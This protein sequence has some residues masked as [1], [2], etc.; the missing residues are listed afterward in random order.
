MQVSLSDVAAKAGVSAATVSR[1]LNGKEQNRIPEATRSRV[2]QVALDLNYHPNR[3]AR[4]LQSRRTMNIGVLL[5]GMLNPFFAELLDTLEEM[6]VNVGYD[7]MPATGRNVHGPDGSAP[8]GWP[9]DGII[10]WALA[11]QKINPAVWQISSSVP[12]VYVGY[13]RTDDTDFVAHDSAQG[14]RLALEHL[15]ERGHRKIAFASPP[16]LEVP[17]RELRKATFEAFC[18][19]RQIEPMR[20][21][22]AHSPDM[23]DWRQSG[24]RSVGFAAGQRLIQFPKNQRPTA[25]YC[26]NDLTALGLI[27]GAMGS[28]LRI[29]DDIAVVGF[30]GI[31]EGKYQVR[32]LTTVEVPTERICAIALDTL[33]RRLSQDISEEPRQVIL[34][35]SLRI[36]ETS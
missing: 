26:F 33:L 23:D 1:V 10:M 11:S 17:T 5:D 6:I 29:P 2:K 25:I 15:W 18:R 19:E 34:P 4:S 12:I 9:V 35:M 36:G 30:D 7:Y 14:T 16:D 24:F 21:D 22:V 32:A 3:L 27:A 28:G 20:I 8:R 31:N 13:A